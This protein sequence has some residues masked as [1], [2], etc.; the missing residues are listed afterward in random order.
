MALACDNLRRFS[1]SFCIQLYSYKKSLWK[2]ILEHQ[3]YHAWLPW[4]TRPWILHFLRSL[5]NNFNA[6]LNFMY[7]I[8]HEQVCVLNFGCSLLLIKN[9]TVLSWAVKHNLH[10]TWVFATNCGWMSLYLYTVYCSS[11]TISEPWES[12]QK[13]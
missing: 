4:K 2:R 10:R 3:E 12:S 5:I 11:D 13:N 1:K 7:K 8:Q 6:K 9:V